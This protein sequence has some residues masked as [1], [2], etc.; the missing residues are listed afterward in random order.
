MTTAI[1]PR[2]DTTASAAL[3]IWALLLGMGAMLAGNGLQSSLLGL[4]AESEG[5]GDGITGLMMS[6]FYLGFLAGSVLTPK[7]LRNVGHVRTFGALA[8]LASIAIL[9][10][11]L[12]IDPAVWTAMRFMTGLS[13]AGLYVVTESWLNHSV[14]NTLRGSILALYWVIGYLGLAA[15]Q[16]MLNAAPPETSDLFILCS[17]VISFALVPILLTATPQ[18]DVS[19]PQS[20]SL[21][22]LVQTAP[23]GAIGCFATGTAQG[24]ILGMA[25]VYASKLGLSV[26]EVS[27]FMIA[28]V[29]GGVV[30]QWPLGKLSDIFDRRKVILGIALSAAVAA[31]LM[32]AVAAVSFTALLLACAV[33]GGLV[34]S[35]YPIFL[36]Y[37]NDWLE[38]NQMVAASGTLVLTFGAGAILG[39]SGAGWLMGM[40]GP[41]GFVAYL[42]LIHLGIAVFAI[43]RMTRR[44][45]P[46][47]QGE[48]VLGPSQPAP[49]AT[50]WAEEIAETDGEPEEEAASELG[51]SVVSGEATE[52]ARGDPPE[53]SRS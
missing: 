8:S 2:P 41:E 13:F 45:A 49:S 30:L 3:K 24:V 27:V 29:V 4:R 43:Y 6:G 16:V 53:S 28:L 1:A 10:H 36:A 20:V 5:F 26:A 17:I 18:P 51:D 31:L 15:G 38:P 11:G 48:Y 14:P 9:V 44:A 52:S 32:E 39:P 50:L 33:M 19:T 22:F 7:M 46:E 34:L 12:F 47:E 35:L 40:F 21:R 23:L 25:P 42:A 37:T